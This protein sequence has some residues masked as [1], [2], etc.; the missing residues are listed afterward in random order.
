MNPIHVLSAQPWVAHLGWTL[1]HFLWQGLSIAALYAGV[2]RGI[3]GK[4]GPNTRYLLAC[5]AL[6]AMLSAPLATWG[7]MGQSD[8]NPDNAYRIRNTP[9]NASTAGAASTTIRLPASVRIAVSSL[10]SAQFLPWAVI[11]W[12]FGASVFWVRLAGGWM[13]AARMQSML[14]R[15]APPAWQQILQGL[16][17]DGGRLA[18]SGGVGSGGSARRSACR[19][20]GG[21]AAA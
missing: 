16:G 9:P 18:A 6:G 13:V 19:A 5:A 2:R 4:V 7:L 11:V 8:T 3:A 12:L 20:S 21:A 15:R 17:A 10:G 1:V 14:V